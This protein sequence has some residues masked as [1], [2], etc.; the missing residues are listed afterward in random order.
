[1]YSSSRLLDIQT[2]HISS[3][4]IH[5]IRR[6]KDIIR[7]QIPAQCL[8]LH[9]TSHLVRNHRNFPRSRL[10]VPSAIQD[11]HFP[12]YNTAIAPTL[13]SLAQD[14][15]TTCTLDFYTD[16]SLLQEGTSSAI[17]G[18]AWIQTN[19]LAPQ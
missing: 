1:M 2:L 14:F 8:F 10:T 17:M 11:P 16:G 5:G 4:Y 6:S 3:D 19:A 13:R 9:F 7:C 18:F 15:F 12:L